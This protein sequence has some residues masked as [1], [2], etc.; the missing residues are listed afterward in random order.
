MSTPRH[1]AAEAKLTKTEAKK[2]VNTCLGAAVASSTSR[3]SDD[4]SRE[5]IFAGEDAKVADVLRLD[6][7]SSLVAHN[8]QSAASRH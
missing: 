2:A 1:L 6:T 7:K 3:N 4:A 8:D 5:K